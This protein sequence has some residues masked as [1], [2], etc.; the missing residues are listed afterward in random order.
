MDA[1]EVKDED[2]GESEEGDEDCLLPV[3]VNLEQGCLKSSDTPW[4]TR[5][6]H[7]YRVMRCEGL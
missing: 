5:D 3:V 6:P 2:K 1:P 4:R 7:G